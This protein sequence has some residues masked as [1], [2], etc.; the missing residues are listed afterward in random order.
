MS[1]Q[2]GVAPGGAVPSMVAPP[3]KEHFRLKFRRYFLAGLAAILPIL[4]TLFI[5]IQV[6]RWVVPHIVGALGNIISL[7]V[8]RLTPHAPPEGESIVITKI[9]LFAAVALNSAAVQTVL[10]ILLAAVLVYLVGYLISSYLGRMAFDTVDGLLARFPIIKVIYPYA[11]QFTDSIFGGEKTAKFSKVVAVQ[12]P[13]PGIYSLGFL[14]G[15]GVD[16]VAKHV[17]RKMV[18]VF[19]PSSPTPVMGYV[20]IVPQ[21]EVIPL[22]IAVEQAFRMVISLGIL[23]P[24]ERLPNAVTGAVIPGSDRGPLGPAR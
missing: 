18:T 24:N 5:V 11:K 9:R 6:Y 8:G 15:T 21:D 19:V 4:L 17:G 10:S 23:S 22:S 20:I 3:Q 1:E 12:Y 7:F 13:R 2:S 16:E 14:V